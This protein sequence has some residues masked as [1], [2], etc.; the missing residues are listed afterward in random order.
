[1]NYGDPDLEKLFAFGRLLITKLKIDD[2]GGPL[3]ID[4]DVKLSYYR[5]TKTHEGSASLAAGET[6]TVTGP[7][8]VGTGRP[9]QEDKAHLSQIVDVLNE[10]FA[11]DFTKEDQLFFDQIVGDLKKDDALGDQARNNSLPQFKLAFDPKGLA[12][13]LARMERNE[14]ISNQFMSNEELRTVALELMMQQVY[15]HFQEDQSPGM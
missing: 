4:D 7:T 6:A 13:V 8:D 11:T 10:R 14:T 2:S 9:M 15:Q 5:L 1:V 12:A 3:I